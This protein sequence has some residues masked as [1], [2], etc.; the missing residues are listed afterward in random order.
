[1]QNRK[2]LSFGL[3][4][5]VF[6]VCVGYLVSRHGGEFSHQD[7]LA[8]ADAVVH[9]LLTSPECAG[10]RSFYGQWN[11]REL[12][13]FTPRNWP[14]GKLNS[15]AGITVY[16]DDDKTHETM[17]GIS[18]NRFELGQKKSDNLSDVFDNP[19]VSVVMF[20]AGRRSPVIGR[21]FVSLEVHKVKNGWEVTMSQLFDP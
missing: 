11:G 13:L 4:A 3:R 7:R 9:F 16:A 20:N 6:L 2:W 8:A 21:C 17:L 1:M 14:R 10:T 5:A 18:I 15:L 12:T 19:P